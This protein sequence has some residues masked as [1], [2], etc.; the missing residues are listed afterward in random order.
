M[1][2]GVA[3]HHVE[4][5]VLE[6][7]VVVG[8]GLQQGVEVVVGVLR[9][10][11]QGGQAGGVGTD[12]V[13]L[14]TLGLG[15]V[16]AGVDVEAQVLEAVDAVVQLQVADR[17]EA[18]GEVVPVVEVGQRVLRGLRVGGAAVVPVE[19]GAVGVVDGLGR[20]EGDGVA[21]GAG[22]APV[23]VLVD[24]LD[25]GVDGQVLVEELRREVDVQVGAL[26]G[27][28]LEGTLVIVVAGAD[29]ERELAAAVDAQVVVRAQGEAVDLVLPVGVLRA[30]QAL[31]RLPVVVAGGEGPVDVVAELVA[32]HH[33]ERGDVL[34]DGGAAFVAHAD[35][36][37]GALLGRD[38]DDAVGGAGAV[39]GGRGGVLQHGVGL[40]VVGVDR[41]ERV[42]HAGTA[43]T[44][45]GHAVD[46]D[47][48]VVGG[49]ERG[50]AADADG[51][52]SARLAGG[53][54]H[55]QARDLAGE[56]LVGG[57]DGAAVDVVGLDGHDGAGHV[58]LLDG[59]VADDHDLVQELIV[60]G[61]GDGGGHLGCL[62]GLRSVADAAHHDGG[63]GRRNPEGEVAVQVGHRTVARARLH[64]GGSDHGTHL[65]HNHAPD[66]IALG[67]CGDAHHARERE[68]GK[69]G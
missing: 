47:E 13:E 8:V 9:G 14:V 56:H 25:V 35:A 50:R 33:V 19:Q 12:V 29:A 28:G 68:G 54:R 64:D 55:E 32:V 7:V 15:D 3:A 42:A 26:V 5:G 2:P 63:I 16:V 44:R 17:A 51:G 37:A 39:D 20:V 36:A 67:P 49:V 58:A 57:V 53:R 22:V 48:R 61:E 66:R 23:G 11:V 21:D 38:D 62:E 18:L 43:V 40:D 34:L 30:E 45:D 10:Q 1:L 24:A 59:A 46:D 41:G 27:T 31:H 65:V 69:D 4:I 60:L 6:V 52:R